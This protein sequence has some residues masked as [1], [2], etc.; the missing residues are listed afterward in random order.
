MLIDERIR[1]AFF[2]RL[3]KIGDPRLTR[4]FETAP[5]DP[6]FFWEEN[7]R[8]PEIFTALEK[9]LKKLFPEN[10]R[11]FRKCYE[12]ENSRF[13]GQSFLDLPEMAF[14]EYAPVRFKKWDFLDAYFSAERRGYH[15]GR[16]SAWLICREHRDVREIAEKLRQYPLAVNLL[17]RVLSLRRGPAAFGLLAECI[18]SARLEDSLRFE[19]FR[20]FLR[21]RDLKTLDFF[22]GLVLDNGLT[23]FKSLKEAMCA[24]GMAALVR[25]TAEEY[26]RILRAVAVGDFEACV[27]TENGSLRLLAVEA[28]LNYRPDEFGSRMDEWMKGGEA[29]RRTVLLTVAGEAERFPALCGRVKGPLS[30]AE[31]AAFLQGGGLWNLLPKADK[32]LCRGLFDCLLEVYDGMGWASVT[33][34]ATESFPLSTTLEKEALAVLL[35]RLAERTED[36]GCLKSLEARYDKMPVAGKA[37]F[38]ERFREKTSLPVISCALEFLKSDSRR[39]MEV[40][41][42]LKITL[43][44]EQ[45]VRVS[46]F[47]KS[48]KQSVKNGILKEFLRS[49]QAEQICD[50]LLSCPE[51]Y[52]RE[53]GADMQE[54]MGKLDRRELDRENRRE[55]KYFWHREK[56]VLT[57]EKPAVSLESFPKRPLPAVTGKRVKMVFEEVGGLVA[58]NRDL[59]YRPLREG[60][61]LTLGSELAPVRAGS[62][63]SVY[64]LGEQFRDVFRKLTSQEILDLDL[65]SQLTGSNDARRINRC[66]EVHG[67]RSGTEEY[68]RQ[69]AKDPLLSRYIL[70]LGQAAMEEWADEDA[71]A[72]F[73]LQLVLHGLRGR[74]FSWLDAFSRASRC[75]KP[76][77]IRKIFYAYERRTQKDPTFD[78]SYRLVAGAYEEKVFPEDYLEYLLIREVPVV[79]LTSRSAKNRDYLFHA[80]FAHPEFRQWYL[81]LQKKAVG[82]EL[83]RGT[84][85]TPYTEFVLSQREL[86]GVDLFA[87]AIAGLRGLTLVRNTDGFFYGDKKNE[88]FSRILKVVRPEEGETVAD[89]EREVRAYKITEKELI[90]AAVYNLNFLNLCDEY[91]KI[92][93]FKSAVLYFAAHLNEKLSEEK[94]EKI[95]EYSHID[96]RDLKDGAFD[97]AWYSDMIWTIPPQTFRQVYENAKYITV[98]GLHKRAQRFFEALNGEISPEEA[99]A[100][101]LESRNKDYCLIY[102]LI[103]LRDKEDL[104]T[105]YLTLSEFL[106]ESKKYGSQRQLSERRVTD[107]A[108]ENLARNAGYEDATVFRCEM[109]AGDEQAAAL[110]G[111]IRIGK[112]TLKLVP[113]DTKVALQIEGENGILS[114]IPAA[115]AGEEKVREIAEQQKAEGARRRRL[116]AGLEEAMEEQT[117]FS[118]AQLGRIA[119][120]PLIRFFLE[121]L[122]LTDGR[123]ACVLCGE[124][125]VDLAG[126]PLPEGTFTIAHPVTLMRIGALREAMKF[127]IGR[128]IRQPFKQVFREIYLLSDAERQAREILRF[129]GFNVDLRRAS[130]ALKGRRWGF[131]EDVGMRKVYYR[132][133]VVAAVFREFDYYYIYDFGSENRELDSVVFLDRK[134]MQALP[135]EQI[136]PVVFSETLRDVDLMIAVSVNN[137]Y[138]YELSM[139]TFEMRRAM[140][141][142]IVELLGLKNITFLKENIKVQGTYGVYVINIK[143]G[144]VFR[145]G[146]GNLLLKTIDNYDKPLALDFIDEDPVT[147]DIITKLLVLSDDAAI[148]DGSILNEIRG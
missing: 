141:E 36:P 54:S 13:F 12:S 56:S 25:F 121:R 65:L 29:L 26:I 52:K 98:A 138:D 76:E 21:D 31:A 62:G 88:V 120:H 102:S 144:F 125:I 136:D 27:R 129:K 92:P 7:I 51:D 97:F 4:L 119:R 100:K 48:K 1:P 109:E 124:E 137:V 57:L 5:G 32:K 86:Y 17:S 18:K 143:T 72:E 63:F 73:V 34:K 101:I 146:R 60:A 24:D 33:F 117:A 6:S 80:A 115:L 140:A 133:G 81:A 130:A 50:Y 71:L 99:K 66:L 37:E 108:F 132:Q 96:Y 9:P 94:I 78:L 28:V 90:R 75:K 85:K 139:S 8:E 111:G 47:L 35:I 134:T 74:E 118:S 59:E 49:P 46:D 84:L 15:A 42:M 70:Q 128:D 68:L 38:L 127:V 123:T 11:E 135:P 40:Y 114:R 89:L 39:G 116:K 14:I 53:I 2:G 3:K 82:L 61:A 41:R 107:I 105:R 131:S 30:E 113:T 148:R 147:A 69:A 142:S 104:W 22:T 87:R 43:N 112:Y 93:G 23:R 91:L 64:P 103:P 67:D 79:M 145:E 44:F 55:E 95:R 83:E 77:N 110:Y 122:I 19:L 10:F 106:R 58:K 16:V 45:A 20:I 126:N